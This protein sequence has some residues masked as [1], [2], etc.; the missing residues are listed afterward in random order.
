MNRNLIA[1]LVEWGLYWAKARR[2]YPDHAAA[3]AW[4]ETMNAMHIMALE[5]Q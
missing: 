2:D 5:A 3:C 1:N 4:N